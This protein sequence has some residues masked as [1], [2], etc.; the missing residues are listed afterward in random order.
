MLLILFST[1]NFKSPSYFFPDFVRVYFLHLIHLSIINMIKIWLNFIASKC[2]NVMK[3]YCTKLSLSEHDLLICLIVHN[4][5]IHGPYFSEGSI[6]FNFFHLKEANSHI[7][8]IIIT[9][10]LT[11][12]TENFYNLNIVY[13]II[14]VTN[15]Y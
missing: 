6:S 3:L 7:F 2:C 11:K 15:K 1:T 4:K 12:S 13:P 8:T 9:G 5:Y 14:K 10:W